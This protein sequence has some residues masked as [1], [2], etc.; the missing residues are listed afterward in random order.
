MSE[1]FSC[2]C[3]LV[4]S[5]IKCVLQIKGNWKSYKRAFQYVALHNQKL[6]Y[7]H[8]SVALLRTSNDGSEGVRYNES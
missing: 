4:I 5:G 7:F 2:C 6:G 3:C 8:E 1:S